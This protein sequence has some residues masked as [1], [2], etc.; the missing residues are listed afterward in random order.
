VPSMINGRL[1][2]LRYFDDVLESA[3]AFDTNG[4]QIVQ[5]LVQRNPHKLQGLNQPT[6][7]Q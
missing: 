3:M 1:G 5:I 7:I 2:L 4:E 6:S